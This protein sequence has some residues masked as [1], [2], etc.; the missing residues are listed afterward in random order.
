MVEAGG[1]SWK[2]QVPFGHFKFEM[3]VIYPSG[4]VKSGVGCVPLGFG[5]GDKFGGIS[6]KMVFKVTRGRD[7]LWSGKK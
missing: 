1:K 5:A 4:D 3:P 6:I 2:L 7:H